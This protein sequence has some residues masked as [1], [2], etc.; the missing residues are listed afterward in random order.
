MF[1]TVLIADDDPRFRSLVK[2]LLERNPKLNVV[3]EAG[4]GEEAVR[5]TRELRPTI[6][7]MDISMPHINGLEATRRSKV[8][9]P[10]T[11]VII[12]TVHAEEPYRKA[13]AE[14][15]ADSFIP[16]KTLAAALPAKIRQLMAQ[17]HGRNTT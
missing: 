2:R 3:G 4:D 8:E 10:E 11:K 14:S 15:G 16:K 9:Q 5:L 1:A 13:A 7:L 6:V 17:D 12:L